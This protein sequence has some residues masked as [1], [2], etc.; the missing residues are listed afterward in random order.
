ML[1]TDKVSSA[2]D[3]ALADPEADPGVRDLFSSIPAEARESVVMGLSAGSGDVDVN[4]L[5]QHVLRESYL[6]SAEELQTHAD[7]EQYY[8]DMKSR[9]REVLTGA[10]DSAIEKDRT[11]QVDSDPTLGDL[12]RDEVESVE[13]EP[14]VRGVE[15]VEERVES[16]SPEEDDGSYFDI[17]TEVDVAP[18][19]HGV[20][21]VEDIVESVAPEG[22]PEPDTATSEAV[23]SGLSV[24]SEILSA[25]DTDELRSA[26]DEGLSSRFEEVMAD[27]DSDPEVRGLLEKMTPERRQL[28]VEGLTAESGDVD[29]EKVVQN[30]F[31]VP[32]LDSDDLST[33]ADESGISEIEAADSSVVDEIIE[34]AGDDSQL[35]SVDL[36]DALQR[37][38]QTTQQMSNMSKMLHDT[39]MAVI[40][41][42][43]VSG[44]VEETP[45][46]NPIA[47]DASSFSDALEHA[48]AGRELG[49]AELPSEAAV[50]SEVFS[51]DG[52]P[53]DVSFGDGAADVK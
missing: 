34:S 22:G 11:H 12:A 23:S 38:Q 52:D 46:V 42:V 6:E 53:D 5:V 9:V 49:E 31:S 50:E 26:L 25:V 24:P 16:V 17:F 3:E 27:P 44:S 35:A 36:Q 13:P 15:A 47:R 30:V 29:V 21:T 8:E 20:G 19:V 51:V 1:D 45:Q 14:E 2:L 32:L 40:G 4:Q 18:E 39:A 28:L 43:G 10:R 7:R 41:K 37:Q 48:E 33:V